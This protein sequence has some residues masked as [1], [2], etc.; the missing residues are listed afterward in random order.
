MTTART[1]GQV[2]REL[3]RR[4]GWYAVVTLCVTTGK[5][6]AGLSAAY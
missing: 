6:P 4:G 3:K 5:D 2:S 1:L